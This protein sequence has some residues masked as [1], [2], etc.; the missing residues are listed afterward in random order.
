MSAVKKIMDNKRAGGRQRRYGNVSVA[1]AAVTWTDVKSE[2]IMELIVAASEASGAVRFG[3]SRDGGALALGVYGDGD[4]GYTLYSPTAE[5]MEDH[6]SGLIDVF[7]TIRIENSGT[8][9]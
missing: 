5:G 2:N 9:R 4:E 3:L 6:I 8:G 1:K 7:N